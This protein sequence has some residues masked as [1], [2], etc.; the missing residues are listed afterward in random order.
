MLIALCW[1]DP[2]SD[3]KLVAFTPLFTTCSMRPEGGG[4]W[5]SGEAP[6]RGVRPFAV[7]QGARQ[8]AVW[9]RRKMYCDGLRLDYGR[10]DK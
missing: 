1:A 5:G 3:S 4:A 6:S 2:F 7:A 9:A 8:T 10:H